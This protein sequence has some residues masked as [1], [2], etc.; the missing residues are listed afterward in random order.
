M[1]SS[2][3]DLVPADVFTY[4]Q[5]TDA[6]NQTRVD[7]I[8]PMPMNESKLR[9]Y[10]LIYDI[11]L[12]QSVVAVENGEILGLAMLGIR[13]DK[14]WVT[15]LG[16]VPNGR[17]R[18]LGRCLID[19]LIHNSKSLGASEVH[20]EVIKNNNAAE[21]LFRRCGFEPERE[22]LVV[23]RPPN[24]INIVTLG[25]YIELLGYQDFWD[26][27]AIRRDNPSWVTANESLQNAGNI[28]ALYADLPNGDCGWLVYQN[29][30]F[31]LTRLVIQTER[32]DSDQVIEALLQNLH[33]RHAI[34]DSIY[35]NL[36]ADSPYWSTLKR[37][38]Y[39]LSFSR[40]EMKLCLR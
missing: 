24:P 23:R 29:T 11:D 14:T 36:P 32:G 12:A 20:L 25:I 39:I 2:S 19:R 28:T 38:G 9:E 3:F 40:V 16:V 35:E 6:Y 37:M 10:S 27:L 31:Q 15:R 18:G 22:L 5:L 1:S 4:R 26:L 33:W 13:G 30:V 8:V 21:T 34:Q 7:Y 17:K